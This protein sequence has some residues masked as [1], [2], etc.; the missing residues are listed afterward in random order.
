MA[1]PRVSWKS[2]A[3]ADR[4]P[5][6]RGRGA[7]HGQDSAES[8]V[9][10]GMSQAEPC[11]LLGRPQYEALEVGLVEGPEKYAVNFGQ[12]SDEQ[13]PRDFRNYRRQ[14]WISSELTGCPAYRATVAG[15]AWG[16]APRV[17]VWAG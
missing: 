10:I 6:G 2:N 12:G 17:R 13:S 15:H 16:T 4:E 5:K 8:G 9:Q 11:G 14:Q 7:G 3:R 1:S